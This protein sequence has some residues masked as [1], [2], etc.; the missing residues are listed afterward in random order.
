MK[1]LI[2][3]ALLAISTFL[4]FA[5]SED[6]STEPTTTLTLEQAEQILLYEVLSDT[7]SAAKRV[8]ELEKILKKD[9]VIS[10]W[11]NQYVVEQDCWFFFID[12]FW[13]ANWAHPCRYV[14]VY[15]S[16]ESESDFELI[17]ENTPPNNIE[18]LVEVNF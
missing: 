6:K 12:D 5:C 3:I 4:L 13:A 2:N 8:Y 11:N 9:S 16:N 10:S 7:V 1:R 17:N 18:K 15:Y 14:F